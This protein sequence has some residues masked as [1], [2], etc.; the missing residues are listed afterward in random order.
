MNVSRK[1]N[2]RAI[3][4][5]LSN[6]K[7]AVLLGPRSS[8]KTH[9][10]KE[11]QAAETW[12]KPGEVH[13]F[14]LD[15][16]KDLARLK[17]PEIALTSLSGL[18]ILDGIQRMPKLLPILRVLIDRK[19]SSARFLITGD[20]SPKLIDG[21]TEAF[22][23]KISFLEVTGLSLEEI[24]IDSLKQH[25]W[26]GG[27]PEAYFANSDKTAQQW[28]EEYIR[29]FLE[30]DIPRLGIQIPAVTLRRFWTMVAH[31]HGQVLK[32]SELARSLGCSEPTARRYLDL[33][34]D[35]YMVRQLRP[36]KENIRKRQV[37]APKVYIR[38]SGVCHALL[39]IPNHAS[40][41]SHPKIGASWEG[42]CLEQI[43]AITGDHNAYFWATHGGAELDLLLFHEDQRL[44]FEFKYTEK[45]S[46][47][48]S[49]RSAQEDL[50]L[51]HLYVVHPG[52]HSYPLDEGITATTLPDFIR[53]F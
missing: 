16:S 41:Q 20:T 47:S 17:N 11:I 21:L 19:D 15:S 8:G 22:P 1:A 53:F 39:D 5:E 31:C 2:L 42:Y 48:K 23:Q 10:A 51:D 34:S 46:T 52:I 6:H 44:G 38:D 40:L 35:T 25:W 3:Q 29:T 9:L 12:G 36:R 49:M 13:H 50:G 28:H 14:D 4:A 45:P 43:L 33:L 7:A 18:I 32:L 30:R 27:Y 37:K 26:R 24:G